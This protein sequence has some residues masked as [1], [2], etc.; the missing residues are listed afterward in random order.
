M[1]LLNGFETAKQ[2][3]K[4][5]NENELATK[6]YIVALTVS[7]FLVVREKCFGNGMDFFLSKPI[8][9]EKMMEALV[10]RPRGNWV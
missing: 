7:S 1:P 5:E 8:K 6:N 9:F 4:L 3:R 10:E 2:I